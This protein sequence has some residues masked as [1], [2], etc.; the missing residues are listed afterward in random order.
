MKIVKKKTIRIFVELFHPFASIYIQR[1]VLLSLTLSVLRDHH[2]KTPSILSF[3]SFARYENKTQIFATEID[4]IDISG[5]SRSQLL[6]ILRSGAA[7]KS[8]TQVRKILLLQ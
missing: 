3:G 2:H 4:K 6:R 1:P 7:E 5:I 8:V